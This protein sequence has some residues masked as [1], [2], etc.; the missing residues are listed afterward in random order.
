MISANAFHSYAADPAAFRANLLVDVDGHPRRFGDVMDRW[1]RDDF[2]AMDPALMKCNGRS[3][4][5]AT[6]RHY[7]ERGRGHSKTTDLAVT[8]CW[9]LAFSARPI[10]GFCYAA[11]RDQAAILKQ[12]IHTLVRLNPWLGGILSVEAHRVVNNARGHPGAGGTLAIEASDVGS[13]YG[14]LPDLIIADELVHWQSAPALWHSLISSAAKRSNCLLVVISNAGFADSWQWTVR[15]V[16]RTDPD[17]HFSR[18]DGPKA[19]WLSAARLAEQ[20]RMLPAIA[21]ARLWENQWS[22][23]GGDALTETDI[24][25]AFD[26]R[27]APMKGTEPDWLYVAGV[28][29]GLTR[30]CSAVVV[31]AVPD[32]GKAGK[33][34]LAH[35]KLWR[36]VLG[37]KIDLMDV[38]RHL[39]ELETRY[40]LECIAFDPWQAESMAQRIEADSGRRR[41]NTQ[42]RFG[43]QPF[44]RS[45]PPTG[46][47]L[48]DQATLIIESFVDRRLHC[49][50]DENLR[51]DLMKLRVEERSYGVR[52]TS[53]RDG[54]GHG[55]TFSAF[56]IALLLAHEFAGK[57]KPR[58]GPIGST[59]HETALERLAHRIVSLDAHDAT[60]ATPEDD[61]A[62][63]R[64]LMRRVGRASRSA[65]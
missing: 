12:S 54:Q 60:L 20:R 2:R 53:P 1:Q 62:P 18:L 28:D 3:N 26:E 4:R 47:N 11:D 22:S 16:A 10:R 40:K 36:P 32:G 14:I 41:R 50:P 7:R 29:L 13:S 5:P 30:D 45:V 65:R 49:Y 35:T 27:L 15:E 58:A 44:M 64:K 61:Q 63:F 56:S 25:A 43:S 37:K 19:S 42:R 38:E 55:D 48:R 39:L 24:A 33:I 57:A 34:R 31:L 59:N 9:A 21:Y 46:S 23:G 17:W 6:M 8:C 51:R 52:L